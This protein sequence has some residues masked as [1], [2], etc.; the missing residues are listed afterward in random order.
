MENLRYISADSHLAIFVQPLEKVK[1]A[2][3][4]EQTG[5]S[6]LISLSRPPIRNRVVSTARFS[7]ER[8]SRA[9]FISSFGP[10]AK[11]L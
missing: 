8:P 1:F 7:A 9:V 10:S 2:V 3:P 4:S 5:P 11:L 6:W